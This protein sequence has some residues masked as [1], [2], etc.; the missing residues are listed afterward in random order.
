VEVVRNVVAGLPVGMYSTSPKLFAALAVIEPD[1]P[2]VRSVT[3]VKSPCAVSWMLTV[4][5]SPP[6]MKRS[7]EGSGVYVAPVAWTGFAGACDAPSWVRKAKFGYSS[8][9]TLWQAEF[10]TWPVLSFSA[11]LQMTIATHHFVASQLM[12]PAWNGA[13]PGG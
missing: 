1:S 13:Q 6:F 10:S 9:T 3:P 8:P 5:S 7:R 12:P 4:S 2:V 11:R